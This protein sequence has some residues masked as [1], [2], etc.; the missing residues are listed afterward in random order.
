[1]EYELPKNIPTYI[2]PRD[3]IEQA[4]ERRTPLSTFNLRQ[5]LALCVST[6]LC[7][8]RYGIQDPLARELL[9]TEKKASSIFRWIHEYHPLFEKD[10]DWQPVGFY[11]DAKTVGCVYLTTLGLDALLRDETQSSFARLHEEQHV[12]LSIFS[13]YFMEAVEKQQNIYKQM[14]Q[15]RIIKT[16]LQKIA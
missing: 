12:P 8:K 5:S 6:E 2:T 16:A 10:V 13:H 11:P 15:P 14:H 3:A 4:Q 9:Y 1:M 7:G